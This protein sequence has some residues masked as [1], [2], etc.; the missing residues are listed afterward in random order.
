MRRKSSMS[1]MNP[2]SSHKSMGNNNNNNNSDKPM[3]SILP[4]T[5]LQG[6]YALKMIDLSELKK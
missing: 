5:A 2:G 6:Q 4:L 1:T 3:Q